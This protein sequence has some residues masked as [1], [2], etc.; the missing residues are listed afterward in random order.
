[1]EKERG[2]QIGKAILK[3]NV[4]G[5]SLPDFKTYYTAAKIKMWY[6]QRERHRSMEE[7]PESRKRPI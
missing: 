4:G 3:K 1:M 5:I 2:L 7:N 6:W